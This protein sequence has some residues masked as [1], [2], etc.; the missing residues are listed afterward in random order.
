MKMRKTGT[1]IALCFV[2]GITFGC[3][4]CGSDDSH[5]NPTSDSCTDAVNQA[6]AC[7]LGVLPQEEVNELIAE[8]QN[9]RE[10]LEGAVDCAL[11]CAALH[12][13]TS[14]SECLALYN[15]A[16]GTAPGQCNMGQHKEFE[17][18]CIQ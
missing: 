8:C 1:A 14:V 18:W 10:G 3:I 12:S 6:N 5:H 4:A 9:P 13:G 11:N 15:C 2:L 16:C 7:A 17:D